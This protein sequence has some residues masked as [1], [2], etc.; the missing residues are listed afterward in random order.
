[1]EAVTVSGEMENPTSGKYI[2]LNTTTFAFHIKWRPVLGHRGVI[3]AVRRTKTVISSSVEDQQ[4][5]D[6]ETRGGNIG[7]GRDGDPLSPALVEKIAGCGRSDDCDT[8]SVRQVMVTL[9]VVSRQ[10][11]GFEQL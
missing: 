4:V 3:K 5:R 6:C 8:E 1:M 9:S 2:L 7:Q 10:A 11:L